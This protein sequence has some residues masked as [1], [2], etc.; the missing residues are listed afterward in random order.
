MKPD[1]SIIRAIAGFIVAPVVPALLV[2]AADAGKSTRSP[3][4]LSFLSL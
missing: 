3:S 4:K 2:A 1:C